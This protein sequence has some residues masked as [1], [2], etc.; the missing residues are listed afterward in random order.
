[1]GKFHGNLL[2]LKTKV[3][4]HGLIGQWSETQNAQKFTANDGGI[5]LWY[6]GTQTLQCQGKGA[7]KGKIEELIQ[8][9]NGQTI[10]VEEPS[11]AP[12]TRPIAFIVY[13]HDET[14]R[15]QLELILKKMDIDHFIL[16]KTS[17]QGLTLIEA[18][19]SQVG[20]NGT[21]NAGIVLLTPDDTGY[22]KR[23]GDSKAKD[24]ARQ[25]VILEM[26][27]LIAKLGRSHTMILV[28]GDLERP[29]DTDGIIYHGFQKHVKEVAVKLAERLEACGFTIDHKKV[30][31]AIR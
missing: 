15:D 6:N 8:Q 16:A 26:G 14:S 28:K 30:M 3:E 23:D 9:L 7:S 5:L 4:E 18:L 19:E 29:S 11:T 21:A 17:G 24:R 2:G 31:D 1:M 27:M 10:T 12:A 13:G 22:A 25:N 20:M